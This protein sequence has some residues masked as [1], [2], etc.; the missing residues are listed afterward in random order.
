MTTAATFRLP[1]TML[2]EQVQALDRHLQHCRAARGHWF[3]AAA[4]AE[5]AHALVAPRFVTTLGGV[6]LL[7]ALCTWW[8]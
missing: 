4:W 2:T 3:G 8:T 7:L 6:A 1:A 5:R